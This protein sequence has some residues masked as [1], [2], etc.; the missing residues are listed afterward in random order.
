MIE[1]PG[2]TLRI[3]LLAGLLAAPGMAFAACNATLTAPSY[4]TPLQDGGS[5]C[6]YTA[7]PVAVTVSGWS[8]TGLAQSSGT[9]GNTTFNGALTVTDTN[10]NNSRSIFVNGGG[11]KLTVLKDVVINKTGGFNNAAGIQNGGSGPDSLTI[12]GNTTVTSNVGAPS[13]SYSTRDG[14]RNNSGGASYR[15]NLSIISQGGTRSG[16]YV[17]ATTVAVGGNLLLDFQSNYYATNLAALISEGGV[18]TVAGTSLIKTA[19]V[20]GATPAVVVQN[21]RVTLTGVA[22]ITAAGAG[23]TAV[24]VRAGGIAQ[25]NASSNSITASG[26]SGTGVLVRGNGAFSA[27]TGLTVDAQGTSFNYTGA[28]S[29]TTL[30]SVTAVTA[31]V[32]W[33]A[34]A[35]TNT[36]YNATQGHY[37]GASLL[38]AGGR[39]NLNLSSNALWEAT[40]ASAFTS[41]NLQSNAVLDASLPP[42]L[43]AV[44]DVT[45]AGGVV[46]LARTDATPTNTLALTGI[47]TANGG[48]LALNTRLND[49]ST[50]VSDVLQVTSTVAGG[51]PTVIS[52][53]PDAASTPALTTGKGILVV[54][55]TGGAGSSAAGAFELKDGFLD[56]S[57]MRYELVRD[58][59]DGNWY[60]QSRALPTLSID[61]VSVIEGNAGITAMQFTV[62]LSAP[63][64]AA[65]V[66][67]DIATANGTAD[68]GS[69]YVAQSLTSVLI[70]GGQSTFTFTVQVNG[71]TVVEPDE[72]LFVNLSNVTNAVMNNAQ[73]VGVIVNDDGNGSTA[74]TPVPTLGQWSLLLLSVL[75]A[76][77]GMRR[78][79]MLTTL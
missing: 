66:Q 31:P 44:G 16:L 26:T 36:T 45:N 62:S 49:A 33:R 72:T 17:L 1:L 24:D 6:V 54:Q 48:T 34:D 38:T 23:S 59:S 71:D 4:A 21:S 78:T 18:T 73:G 70:P 29:T 22:T 56:A 3:P 68:A 7:D 76:A 52:V 28:T 55:V 2:R 39:L 32:V 40:A 74:V 27:G 11:A 14:V 75:L 12:Y 47:Y 30:D 57:G 77:M 51:A 10:G 19:T 63:A 53:L 25:L 50:S 15:Q 35:S 41:L 60:L 37:K 58:A 79:R 42:S 67:F 46:S 61:N 8:A 13:A 9:T 5:T 43:A 65:G 64:P 69:D 20:S